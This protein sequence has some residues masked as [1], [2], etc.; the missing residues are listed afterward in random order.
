MN[1]PRGLTSRTLTLADVEATIAMV[2]ACE[3]HDS[4]ELMWE[5][6]D[7]LSDISGEG[8]DRDRDWVGV[9]DG[10]RVVAWG[11]YVH[12]RR[13]WA[14][15]HPDFRGRGVGT[16]LRRWA[17]ERGRSRGADRVTQ[18]IDDALPDT[19]AMFRSAG[20]T[21]RHTSWVLR[22]D[23]PDEPEPPSP[24]PGIVLRPIRTDDE[25]ATMEMFETAFSEFADRPP[26]S[27]AT[28]RAMTVEREGFSPEDLI[29]AVDGDRVVGGAVL[30][31]ADEIW[32]D[33]L[34]VAA[35]HRHRGIARALLH[36]AFVRSFSRGYDHT[37]LSTDSRT[38]AL[39]LYERVGMRVARSY[40]NWGLD[41]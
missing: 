29:V 8:F 9:F 30:L 5:R 26:S 22:I 33:K 36:T 15:V 21:P 32:V 16:W 10:D 14:D 6:A 34:A 27:G 20:Y 2:N 37:A 23:H 38:G 13:A 17:Q 3:L 35:T 28:W 1:R 11:L 31:D 7:L 19:A 4:G 39:S 24:P 18:V 41:L 25:T 12:P 40:T